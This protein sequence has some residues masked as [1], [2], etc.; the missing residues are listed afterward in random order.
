MKKYFPHTCLFVIAFCFAG[1]SAFAQSQT[2][3][4]PSKQIPDVNSDIQ[5][6]AQG[7]AFVIGDD[8]QKVYFA[9]DPFK[10]NTHSQPAPAGSIAPQA[11]PPKNEEK[12]E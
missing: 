9:T 8:G 3:K 4:T 7:Q 2:E 1:S 5:R 11:A 10:Q 12:P 6:D